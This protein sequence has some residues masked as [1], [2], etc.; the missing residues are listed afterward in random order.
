MLKKGQKVRITHP[1][2]LI[3]TDGEEVVTIQAVAPQF[4]T[5]D[6]SFEYQDWEN[7]L[8]VLTSEGNQ[9]WVMQEH[10]QP[11]N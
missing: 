7:G 2:A 6:P 10:V 9:V 5:K 1:I 11:L 3:F 8:E 4:D